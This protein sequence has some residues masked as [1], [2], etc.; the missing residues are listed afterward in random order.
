MSDRR[1]AAA[2]SA[3]RSG[4]LEEALTLADSCRP[5]RPLPDVDESTQ[6]FVVLAD[7]AIESGAVE[8]AERCLRAGLEHYTGRSPNVRAVMELR[9]RIAL[10]LVAQGRVTEALSQL[11]EITAATQQ[12]FGLSDL[13]FGLAV[14]SL[15]VALRW[16]GDLAGARACFA[17]AAEAFAVTGPDS[18]H[19]ATVLLNLSE[20]SMATG[21]PSS[22]LRGARRAVAIWERHADGSDLNLG[23]AVA[24]LGRLLYET[25]EPSEAARCFSRAADLLAGHLGEDHP[26]VVTHRHN[27]SIASAE[28]AEMHGQ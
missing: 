18:E 17:A 14:N 25:G 8:D 21:D 2:V 23:A 15:G 20:L 12:A 1:R 10:L 16:T 3:L 22:G 9:R 28:A 13:Q 7:L 11:R 6:R 19:T 27:Q 26:E 5:G 4:F 24:N